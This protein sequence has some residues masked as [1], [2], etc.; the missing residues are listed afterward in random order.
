[1]AVELE[2][3]E[4]AQARMTRKLL[5]VEDDREIRTLITIV[6]RKEPLRILEAING[7]ETLERVTREKFDLIMLDVLLPGIDGF[8]VL[9]R[10]RTDSPNILTPVLILTS[11]TQ[12]DDVLRGYSLGATRYMKKPFE[13]TELVAQVRHLAGLEETG[14]T[15]YRTEIRRNDSGDVVTLEL[16]GAVDLITSAT[17]RD[18]LSVHLHGKA[19]RVILDV[20]RLEFLDSAGI[21][22]LLSAWRALKNQ[23]GQLLIVGAPP[24]I[25]KV[26]Q[27]M[28]LEGLLA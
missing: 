8:E 6:L 15:S 1:M 21:T 14:R 7:I 22:V 9:R 2:R 4:R 17:V 5:L 10:I 27:L 11:M 23:G 3:Q 18:Q 13:P 24:Q 16:S 19:R 26:F 28:G 20:S 25:R 12:G